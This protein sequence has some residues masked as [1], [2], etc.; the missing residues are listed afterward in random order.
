[1][2]KLLLAS[3]CALAFATAALAADEFTV[4]HTFKGGSVDGDNPHSALTPD[5]LG[6]FYGTTANGGH[7]ACYE[8][9][10][11]VF[12]IA[13][14]GTLT[15]LHSFTGGDD[16]NSPF[17]G[18]ILASDGSL[19]GT[20]TGGGVGQNGTVYRITPDGT[21]KVV[22][23]FAG[24]DDGSGPGYKIAMD[25]KSNI[26]GITTFGGHYSAGTVYKINAQGKEIQLHA[27]AENQTDGGEPTGGVIIDKAGNL[28]GTTPWGG[29]NS[30]TIFKVTP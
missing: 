5:G 30:G 22:Y 4:V 17:G 6:N 18:V 16:G 3:V 21:L 8:G 20:A 11:T 25:K 2:S 9:C 7:K 15:L 14:D 24:G 23:A 10:G 26:Y 28:F 19:Y 29:S 12:R 27:F 13:T 1:M